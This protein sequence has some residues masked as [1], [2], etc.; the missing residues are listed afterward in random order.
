MPQADV[1]VEILA[2]EVQRGDDFDLELQFTNHSSQRR[3]VDIYISGNVVY[4]TGVPSD[5]VIFET[6]VVKLEPQQSECVCLC[7][8]VCVSVC[9]FVFICR[10]TI[11]KCQAS[12]KTHF[13][14]LIF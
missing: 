13:A 11:S 4:Y 1:E 5:E 6:P 8:Y 9:L 2:L 14:T 3:V 10:F 12:C 7:M